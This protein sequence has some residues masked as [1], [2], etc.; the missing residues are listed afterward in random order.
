MQRKP[1][2]MLAARLTLESVGIIRLKNDRDRYGTYLTLPDL[3]IAKLT[4]SRRGLTTHQPATEIR[5]RTP[6]LE[7][8]LQLNDLV[9]RPHPGL[10][11]V[12]AS[13][14]KGN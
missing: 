10:R 13:P 8:T 3:A 12:S 5:D 2:E 11:C 9:A 7:I 14:D 6:L 4:G 1:G